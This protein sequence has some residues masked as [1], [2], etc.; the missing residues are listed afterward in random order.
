MS[1]TYQPP[2]SITP[3]IV[4]LV[5]KISEAVG[6]LTMSIDNTQDLRLRRANRIQTI[7]GSLAIEGNTLSE[8]QITAILN[9]KPVIAPPRE[10]QEVKNAIAAYD[11]LPVWHPEAEAHM[12][13]AHDVLMSGILDEVGSYRKGGVGVMADQCAIHMASST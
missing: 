11:K 9:G 1:K 12:L 6:R 4:N 3:N 2:Y 7:H 5:A 8:S 13:N 10:I